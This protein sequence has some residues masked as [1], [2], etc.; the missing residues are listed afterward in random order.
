MGTVVWLLFGLLL[1]A[2]LL[3]FANTKGLR[4]STKLLGR[5]LMVAALIY[6]GFAA[7]W[8]NAH[9]VAIEALGVPTSP[10]KV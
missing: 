6:I 10:F 8:G 7:V 3:Y 1:V 5:A 4:S 2:P 9:W